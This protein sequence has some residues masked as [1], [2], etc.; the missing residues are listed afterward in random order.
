MKTCDPDRV[1]GIIRAVEEQAHCQLPPFLDSYHFWIK[2][3][4]E[5][6]VMVFLVAL[7]FLVGGIV[8]NLQQKRSGEARKAGGNNRLGGSAD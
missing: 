7:A 3:Y 2:P 6:G 8:A 4:L 5:P 1:L